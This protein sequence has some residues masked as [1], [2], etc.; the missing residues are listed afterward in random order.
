MTWQKTTF[1]RQKLFDEVWVTPVTKLAQDYGMSDV[2]LRKICITLDIPMPPRGYWAKIAAGKKI[3][4]PTLHETTAPTTY[5]RVMNIV[6]VDP[7]VEERVTTARGSTIDV[8]RP[9]GPDYI[10]PPDPSAVS[11]QAKLVMRAMKS[12]KLD[13]GALSSLG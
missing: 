5:Q 6:E 13:E 1:E 8:A 4:K 2:G 12:T 11:P 3:S 7:V 9:D 10:P